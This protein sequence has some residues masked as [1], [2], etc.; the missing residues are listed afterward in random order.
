MLYG[1]NFPVMLKFL[2]RIL[3]AALFLYDGVYKLLHFEEVLH[4]L[5]MRGVP[6]AGL[7]L[8]LAVFILLVGSA[9]LIL[10]QQITVGALLLLSFVLSATLLFHL[11]FTEEG[12]RV[13]FLKNFALMGGLLMI[14]AEAQTTISNE[15]SHKPLN[16]DNPNTSTAQQRMPL[17]HG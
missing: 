17:R 10:G 13:A 11:D 9:C 7:F 12:E 8:T 6:L 5:V 16:V 14:V 3:T 15:R 1:V 2:A 4:I